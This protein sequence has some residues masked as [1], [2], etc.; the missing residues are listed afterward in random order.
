MRLAILV[1]SKG[2]VSSWVQPHRPFSNVQVSAKNHER[3]YD[4]FDQ[5]YDFNPQ[6]QKLDFSFER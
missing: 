1:Q 4:D 3:I 2:S 6:V 5:L